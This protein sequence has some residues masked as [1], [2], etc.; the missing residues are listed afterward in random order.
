MMTRRHLLELAAT[1]MACVVTGLSVA[2]RQDKLATVTLTID[3]M[4]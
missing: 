4:T 2:A 3:G 1:A